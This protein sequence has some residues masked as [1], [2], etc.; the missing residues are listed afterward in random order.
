MPPS[1]FDDYANSYES[2]LQ[3]GLDVSGESSEYF[4]IGRVKWVR[5]RLEKLLGHAPNLKSVLDFGCGTGNSV[6]FLLSELQAEHVTGIDTS[7][8]SLVQA[9]ARYP[10]DKT[11]FVLADQHDH[12][13]TFD[14]AF[15][16]GV[17]HHIPVELRSEVVRKIYRSI[18]LGGW[19]A[20]WENNPWN[21][22]TRLV[23]SRIPF[24]RDAITLSIP[25]SKRLLKQAGFEV[26]AVDTC[27]YFP[28]LLRF[29]RSVEPSLSWLP[30]GAQY[31]VLARKPE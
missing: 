6:A 31:I 28:N 26:A 15:C 21:P 18:K 8:Q 22:G 13:E 7:E 17:F 19:F 3:K 24:D 14:L 4:A 9:R 10:S 30:L 5:R 1:E 2:A 29:F 20:F 27:F 11:D 23:M 12:C 25:E 16:N